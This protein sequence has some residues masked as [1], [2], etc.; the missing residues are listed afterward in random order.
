AAVVGGRRWRARSQVGTP[1]A[2]THSFNGTVEV[3]SDGTVAVMF[4]DLRSNTPD[5]GLPTDVWL[6]LSSDGGATFSEQH[7]TGPFDMRQAPEAGGFFLG[8]YQGMAAA[9]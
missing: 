6:S 7:V 4:Y 2:R 3:T 8:D 1:P 5:A 9:G